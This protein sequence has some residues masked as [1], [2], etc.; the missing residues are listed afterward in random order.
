M[1]CSGK[2]SIKWPKLNGLQVVSIQVEAI[3]QLRQALGIV[4]FNFVGHSLGSLYQICYA[5]NYPNNVESLIGMSTPCMI[6][7]PIQFDSKLLKLP[8]KRKMMK[9][10][11]EFMDKQYITGHTAFSMMPLK[12]LINF[13]LKGRSN[14]STEQKKDICD[15]LSHKLWDKNFAS[16]VVPA[17]MGYLGYAK[18]FTGIS[19]VRQLLLDTDIKIKLFYGENDWLLYKEYLEAF[20]LLKLKID[21]QVIEDTAHQIPNLIPEKITALI[22][23]TYLD[24][25]K[26]K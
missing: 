22:A 13:W 17:L 15:F 26:T 18:D 9:W 7:E 5:Q 12:Q 19:I 23:Q 14:Y 21:F 10:F 25:G 24:F 8:M 16:D 4:K 11:W 20:R 3:E 2:P 1:G 6:A